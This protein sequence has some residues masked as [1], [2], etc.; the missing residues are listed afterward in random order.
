MGPLEFVCMSHLIEG[1]TGSSDSVWCWVRRHLPAKDGVGPRPDTR[2]KE[3]L[4]AYPSQRGL[5][6]PSLGDP[7]LSHCQEVLPCL[8][9]LLDRLLGPFVEWHLSQNLGGHSHDVGA[10]S[11]GQGHVFGSPDA[12]D[13][14]PRGKI[15]LLCNRHV[16]PD[17]LRRVLTGLLRPV[18]EERD[19]CRAGL[20]GEDQ[21]VEG[22]HDSHVRPY[23][24]LRELPHHLQP[25]A[26]TVHGDLD[27]D[28]LV[29]RSV[30]SC[31]FQ[32]FRYSALRRL[33]ADG[34]VDEGTDLQD[35]PL[36]IDTSFGQKDLLVR[37]DPI[38][39]APLSELFDFLQRGGI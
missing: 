27:D 7:L 22:H 1:A 13:Y 32:E 2:R 35:V 6:S 24:F 17:Y 29:P 23:V 34:P 31:L 36:E 21:L 5:P 39:Y 37:C 28:V 11:H 10:G 30:L 8:V 20:R 19:I 16:V 12:P 9:E 26:V 25:P 18:I 3:R 4:T 15:A 33:N 38:G 14:Q